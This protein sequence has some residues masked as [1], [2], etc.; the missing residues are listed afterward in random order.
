M[1]FT[2]KSLIYTCVTGGIGLIFYYI[3]GSLLKITWLGIGLAV[4]FAA[5]GFIV[6]TFQIPDTNGM[7]IT[8]KLGGE[9]IDR[10]ILR[11]LR[12][13]KKGKVIYTYLGTEEER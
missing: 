13:R 5:I 6:G 1:I 10:A 12:F 7:E 8:R 11:W 4:I 9:N 2:T 3:F